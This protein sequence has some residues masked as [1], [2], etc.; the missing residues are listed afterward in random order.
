MKGEKARIEVIAYWIDKAKEALNS[1]RSE[2]MA[3]RFVFAINRAY[4]GCFYSASTVAFEQPF[5]VHW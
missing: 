1:A 5:I 2:Q 4:Y 3:G